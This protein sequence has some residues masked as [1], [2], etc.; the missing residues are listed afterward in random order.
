MFTQGRSPSA[1]CGRCGPPLPVRQRDDVREALAAAFPRAGADRVG[2]GR[3]T[4]GRS[5]I[6]FDG[7]AVRS[8]MKR[9][10]FQSHGSTRSSTTSRARRAALPRPFKPCCRRCTGAAG[11]T[12]R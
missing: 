2:A 10:G 8:P 6:A 12:P 7:D 4:T 3:S 1:T 11:G 9:T 5:A